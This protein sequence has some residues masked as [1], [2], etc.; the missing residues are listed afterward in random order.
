MEAPTMIIPFGSDFSVF[1]YF[2]LKKKAKLLTFGSSENSLAF[3]KSLHQMFLF[4]SG[5]VMAYPSSVFRYD[6]CRCHLRGAWDREAEPSAGSSLP[7]GLTCSCPCEARIAFHLQPAWGQQRRACLI[8][9][10][11]MITRLV[12]GDTEVLILPCLLI[13]KTLLS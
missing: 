4:Y 9:A 5:F 2:S 6:G 3:F 8:L 12:S 7:E 13:Y 1:K 10:E 11:A